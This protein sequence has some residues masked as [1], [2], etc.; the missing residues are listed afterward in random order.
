MFNVAHVLKLVQ[1]TINIKNIQKLTFNYNL[2]FL[3]IKVGI[4]TEIERIAFCIPQLVFS[5]SVTLRFTQYVFNCM[6]PRR[7]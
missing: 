2:S 6:Y 5:A 7:P 3:Q 1:V 4:L